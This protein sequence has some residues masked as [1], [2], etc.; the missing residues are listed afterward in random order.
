MAS[1]PRE[2]RVR[3]YGAMLPIVGKALT[4]LFAGSKDREATLTAKHEAGLTP[5]QAAKEICREIGPPTL[6]HV[7]YGPG[8]WAHMD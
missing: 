4:I 2:W 8:P 7:I 5:V 1:I 3:L 6:R